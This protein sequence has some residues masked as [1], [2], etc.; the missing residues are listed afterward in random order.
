MK[1]LGTILLLLGLGWVQPATAGEIQTEWA[2]HSAGSAARLTESIP[3]TDVTFLANGS[4]AIPTSET[5]TLYVLTEHNFAGKMDEQVQVRWWDGTRAHWVTGFWVRQVDVQATE[6]GFRGQPVEGTATLDLWRIDIP[7]TVTRPGENFYA[8]Q[9]KGYQDDYVE[10]RYLLC[11]AGG[12]FSR[13]NRL[14]QIWSSS[15]EF[16]QQDW[17]IQILPEL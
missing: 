9:L 5:V 17:Q 7:S 10:D 2:Y 11:R 1:A 15:E 8:I 6:D 16:S 12:D 3:G 13:T 4:D 14:G